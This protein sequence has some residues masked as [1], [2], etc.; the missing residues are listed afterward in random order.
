M[1]KLRQRIGSFFSEKKQ[2]HE[3]NE[4]QGRQISYDKPEVHYV[5]EPSPA[6]SKR[7][8]SDVS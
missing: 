4:T 1:G 5:R 6:N 3:Y 7:K 2:A 8:I